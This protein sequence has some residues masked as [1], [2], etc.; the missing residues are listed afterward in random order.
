M[1]FT[2]EKLDAIQV[3]FILCTERTGSSLMSLMLNLHPKI[4]CPSEEQFAL[5][6]SK[7]YSQKVNWTDSDIEMYVDEFGLM[8][9]KNIDLYFSDKDIFLKN[10]KQHREIL[11][12]SRLIKLSYLHF[13]DIKDKNEIEVIVDKQ[14]KYFFHLPEIIS[15]FPESK[16]IVLTRDVRDNIVSK[17]NRALNWS[18]QPYFL[19]YLWIQ[20]YSNMEGLKS[21]DFLIVK[22]EDFILNTQA[23]L[24]LICQFIN[25]DFQLK[26]LDTIGVFDQFIEDKKYKLDKDYVEKLK[27]FHSGLNGLPNS[28]KIGIYKK[29]PSFELSE[30]ESI[31][32]SLLR[33][34]DYPVSLSKS[35]YMP[36]K[37]MYYLFLAK[38]YR[39]YL[40]KF[41]LKIPLF[42]KVFIKSIRKRESVV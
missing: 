2:P 24:E 20:T 13:L 12:Y 16:F 5:Y 6:F 15:L 30:I 37:R 33:K 21:K 38:C 18:K 39:A 4:I 31:C 11:N 1:Q 28:N 42:I 35:K 26:M 25:Q 8:F 17:K 41:Y 23:T 3:H 7:K 36:L 32:G 14:I 22:Y 29:T 34:F 10:L 40:L 9:E 27:D 19:A